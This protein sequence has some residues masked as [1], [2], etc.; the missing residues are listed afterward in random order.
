MKFS[1]R[2]LRL[3][4]AAAIMAGAGLASPIMT[5]AA[6]PSVMQD[7]GAYVKILG[8][9]ADGTAKFQF[10][11]TKSTPASDAAGYWLGIYDVT[12]SHYVWS[13]DTGAVDLPNAYFGNARPTPD[14]PDG[15]YKVVFFVRATYEPATNI[16]EIEFPFTVNH[17]LT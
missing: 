7:D 1:K 9:P 2:P 13:Y 3:L 17:S 6:A 14:L 16:S 5:H 8:N 10:G 15:E 12:N 4:V 11:W